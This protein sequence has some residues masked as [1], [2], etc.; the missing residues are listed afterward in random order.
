MKNIIWIVICLVLILI[1]GS[2]YAKNSCGLGPMIVQGNNALLSQTVATITDGTSALTNLGAITTGTSGC[3]N[4]GVVSIKRQKMYIRHT[5][6]NLE[7]EIAKGQGPYLD[8]LLVVMGC[9]VKAKADFVQLSQ[10]I[11]E[12]IFVEQGNQ[13]QRTEIFWQGVSELLSHPRLQDQ[14][15]SVS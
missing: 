15:Q 1:P 14:C 12:K 5:Y 4:S 11:Y 13:E 9:S 3:S 8:S 6:S 7:E 10:Q 2:L